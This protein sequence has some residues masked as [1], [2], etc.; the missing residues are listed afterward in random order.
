[1]QNK[2]HEGAHEHIRP[3]QD[4]PYYVLWLATTPSNIGHPEITIE[5]VHSKNVI[6]HFSSRHSNQ[7]ERAAGE[8]RRGRG[9]RSSILA[10]FLILTR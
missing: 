1:M 10:I 6:L 8:R 5:S 3:N 7:G 4:I 9:G 2:L